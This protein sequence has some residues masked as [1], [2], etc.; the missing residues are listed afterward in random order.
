M[1]GELT[2]LL[3]S[4]ILVTLAELGD[5]TQIATI[6]LAS[7]FKPFPVFIGGVFGFLIVNLLCFVLGCWIGFSIP[8][9]WAKIFAAIL[10]I[11]F[12]FLLLRNGGDEWRIDFKAGSSALI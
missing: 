3:T 8:Y 6:L 11:F 5:K 9:F 10:F 2:S 12:G 7:K 4:F 1:N